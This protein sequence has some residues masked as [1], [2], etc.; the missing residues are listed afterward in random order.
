MQG[1]VISTPPTGGEPGDALVLDVATI[2]QA[3]AEPA[4][5]G[6]IMVDQALAEGHDPAGIGALYFERSSNRHHRLRQSET[7]MEEFLT[8]GWVYVLLSPPQLA[9][10]RPRGVRPMMRRFLCPGTTGTRATDREA[11]LPLAAPFFRVAANGLGALCCE[12][13]ALR[14]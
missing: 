7:G 5:I 8:G 9:A 14:R 12:V 4:A 11:K 2:D 10:D 6:R 1:F 3:A 13:S